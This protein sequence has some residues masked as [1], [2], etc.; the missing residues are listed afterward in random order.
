M[1]SI[2]NIINYY[3]TEII[4]G[5]FIG[6]LLMLILFI[7]Y[8]YRTNKSIK[9]YNKL[10][11]GSQDINMEELLNN[12]NSNINDI[13]R[14]MNI[15]EENMT[16]LNTKLSFAVQKVGFIRYNAFDDIGSQLS[17]SIALL[18]EFENGFIITSIYGR[19]DNVIYGKEINDGNSRTSLSAEE[20]IAMDRAMKGKAYE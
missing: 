18:D 7:I 5:L 2:N 10:L 1:E 6:F 13:N 8:I 20:M 4:L 9:R 17:F 12:I 14:D 19:N 16:N 11:N 3:N 15:V